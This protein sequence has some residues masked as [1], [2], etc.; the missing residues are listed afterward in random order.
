MATEV[1]SA[2]TGIFF[3]SRILPSADLVRRFFSEKV[4]PN[5]RAWEKEGMF[6]RE[7]FEVRSVASSG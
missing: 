5:V 2:I 6:P 1:H 3:R 7:L 4:E